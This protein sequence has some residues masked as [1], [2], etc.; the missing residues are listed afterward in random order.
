MRDLSNGTRR[1]TM[2]SSHVANDT[3][4]TCPSR[5]TRASRSVSRIAAA[6]AA[7][8]APSSFTS[9]ILFS[10]CATLTRSRPNSSL[11]SASAVA[12]ARSSASWADACAWARSNSMF[13]VCCSVLTE[14][15]SPEI[16]E[17]RLFNEDICFGWR[18]TRPDGTPGEGGG[19]CV[20]E[21]FR[22]KNAE[23]EKIAGSG[24]TTK[25]RV[26]VKPA[27]IVLVQYTTFFSSIENV[28]WL[29]CAQHRTFCPQSSAT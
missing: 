12:E 2:K 25:K 4:H 24:T 17:I 22:Q 11:A 18:S 13:A 1:G 7:A 19:I 29:E 26:C 20:Y 10:N 23:K 9:S 27:I 28:Y 15:S 14:S 21:R 5:T 8:V 3:K 6:F 16:S